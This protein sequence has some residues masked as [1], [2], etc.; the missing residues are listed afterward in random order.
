MAD[1]ERPVHPD[2]HRCMMRQIL[3]MA[4]VFQPDVHPSAYMDAPQR[5][6]TLPN[7][8]FCRPQ[9]G[10]WPN[11]FA[12]PGLSHT[13]AVNATSSPFLPFVAGINHPNYYHNIAYSFMQNMGVAQLQPYNYPVYST[14][15]EAALV[16]NNAS[17]QTFGIMTA[18]CNGLPAQA[19][20]Q[21]YSSTQQEIA[22]SRG[23]VQL[24]S[25]EY[26]NSRRHEGNKS[27]N[28]QTHKE[29]SSATPAGPDSEVCVYSNQHISSSHLQSRSRLRRFTCAPQGVHASAMNRC[30]WRVSS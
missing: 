27:N 19:T 24:D 2:P 5:I 9:T 25:R 7:V 21:C 20:F 3:P 28:R 16:Q 11:T 26:F 15:A 10:A 1:I 6:A 4:D 14:P 18:G 23:E 13:F 12:S 30:A 8:E 29:K 17:D 22:P